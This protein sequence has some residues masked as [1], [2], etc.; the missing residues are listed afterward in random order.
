M[1]GTFRFVPTPTLTRHPRRRCLG[2][3]LPCRRSPPSWTHGRLRRSN[4]PGHHQHPVHDLRP[5]RRRGR[6][7]SARTRADP[8]EGGL[9]RAQPVEIWERTASVHHVGAE[10]DQ[11]VRVATSPR[12]ASPTSVR[13]RWCGT[14]RPAGRTTTRSCGRT[15]APTGSPR[16]STATAAATSS[17]ARPDC[18]PRR[19]SRRARCS[20][21]SRTSTACA[22]TRRRA[23]RSSAPATRW[24]LWNLT[25]GPRGGVHVTDVTNASRTMLMNLETLDWDDELL[26]FFGIP[27][28]MLPEIKPSSLPEAYGTTL[29]RRPARRRGARHRHP[30]RPAGRD[31]RPGV[32]ERGRGQEHLRHGQ[33]PAAQHR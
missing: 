20:G 7:S 14:G 3:R 9:G 19:T 2:R 11:A 13:R 26:S 12:S 4:R 5:R 1:N 33:L 17:A 23:T 32:P 18:R 22:T 6:P 28:Q 31:G 27:R 10:Q 21:S 29:D 24:V 8:A 16:R 30:R 15:P 25:G